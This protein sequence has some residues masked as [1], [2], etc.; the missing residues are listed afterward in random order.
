MEG[1]N[2]PKRA[3]PWRPKGPPRRVAHAATKAAVEAILGRDR[4]QPL[5]QSSESPVTGNPW[6]G[7]R[8]K[9]RSTYSIPGQTAD[10]LWLDKKLTP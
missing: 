10:E 2:V 6:H 7:Q 5:S 3:K 9:R 4:N 1:K 8:K